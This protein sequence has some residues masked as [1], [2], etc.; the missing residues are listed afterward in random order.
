MTRLTLVSAGLAAIAVIGIPGAA[1][2]ARAA[3]YPWCAQYGGDDQGGRNC[4]FSTYEQCMATVSGMGGGCER[5]LFYSG[6]AT[7]PSRARREPER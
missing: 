3:E 2:P 7:K 6:A 4:G 1:Q 5:N